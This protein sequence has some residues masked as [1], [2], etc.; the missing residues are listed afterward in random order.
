[1][2]TFREL[3]ERME[4]LGEM[5]EFQPGQKI[6]NQDQPGNFFY[7]IKSGTVEIINEIPEK[8]HVNYLSHDQCLGEIQCLTGEKHPA[9]AVAM[10][11]VVLYRGSRELLKQLTLEIPEF[12]N[13]II[14]T[15]C[16]R[17]RSTRD[18]CS[19][20]TIEVPSD[21]DIQGDLICHSAAMRAIKDRVEFH[22]ESGHHLFLL[23]EKG[24]G[25]KIIARYIH[26]LGGAYNFSEVEAS[27]SARLSQLISAQVG[28][29]LIITSLHLL[30]YG[31]ASDLAELLK[32]HRERE[33]FPRL[34]FTMRQLNSGINLIRNILT[35]NTTVMEIPALRERREDIPILANMFLKYFA[36]KHN[37][38]VSS[39]NDAAISRLCKYSYLDGNVK[40]LAKIIQRAVILSK[41]PVITENEVVFQ[42]QTMATSGRPKVG[43]AL[44]AGAARGVAHIGV[45]KVLLKH[46]IP[47]D[48]IA[49]TSAGA[50]V[51]CCLA[52][53]VEPEKLERIIENMSWSKIA[54]PLWPKQSF[55]SNVKLG[56]Y[57]E[58][59][60]GK[61][62]FCELDIPF[63]AVATD[64][65]SGEEAVLKHG[66][67]SD[68]VRASTA[69]PVVFEPV[70]L[71]GRT[72]MDGAPVNMLPASVCKSMGADIVIAVS[73][74]DYSFETGPPKNIYMAVLHYMDMVVK[75]QVVEVENQWSDVLIKAVKPGVSGYSFKESKQLIYEGELVAEEAIPRIKELI[76]A[77]QK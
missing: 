71:Y 49:G 31:E 10:N 35:D 76:N 26:R 54:S 32:N 58:K 75:K 39:F 2:K 14:D 56:Q 62:E 68:A 46:N 17:I 73:V 66:K 52:A 57:L 51:G 23:G 22:K 34:I 74:T 70:K 24:V 25:K 65:Y 69:I 67:V 33:S 12:N 63:V 7:V 55:L 20:I 61:K 11:N 1:M 64:V 36:L 9:S 27:E 41:S 44:G 43:L 6:V 16:R 15:L 21:N 48:M 45:A 37:L 30:S 60:I 38:R 47:I 40:E 3:T 18:L 53:G 28:G 8:I 4:K 77:W 42:S 13:Y 59:I 19:N 50:L 72:L 5:V 29:T